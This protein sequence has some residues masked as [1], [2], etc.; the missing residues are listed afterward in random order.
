MKL[1]FT[2]G[3]LIFQ[4]H[5]TFGQIEVYGKVV[6]S[7]EYELAGA[8]ITEVGTNNICIA[9]EAGDF[10]FYTSDTAMIQ[11]SYIGYLDTLIEA[12]KVQGETITLK[13]DM[14][15]EEIALSCWGYSKNF[16]FGYYGDFSRMPF[17]ITTHYF[18][19]SFFGYTFLLSGQLNYKTDFN[20]NYDFKFYLN[21]S[22]VIR[23][24]YYTLHIWGQYHSRQI[25]IDSKKNEI[26][27]YQLTFDN[28]I[29]NFIVGISPGVIYRTE[30]YDT[31][32]QQFGVYMG[33][34]YVV[35]KIN[36]SWY[37]NYSYFFDY[38]E[39]SIAVYQKFFKNKKTLRNFLIGLDYKKYR[40][41]DELNISLKYNYYH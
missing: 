7:S 21:K 26:K 5:F 25:E 12:S 11:I 32:H 33:L 29:E 15:V 2:F 35:S 14:Q 36:Q 1:I 3:L 40:R 31:E 24:Q 18:R 10:K 27:D 28:S 37:F 34:N 41:Y 16:T 30:Q 20:T 17:G 38:S 9:N 22:N 13:M 6:D 39:Y 4:C 23:S 19:P 8:I